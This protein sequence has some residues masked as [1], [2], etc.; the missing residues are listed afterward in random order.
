MFVLV[1]ALVAA[2]WLALSCSEQVGMQD[3]GVIYLFSARHF[4]PW[5]AHDPVASVFAQ[6]SPFPPLFPL[7]L[8]LAGGG[9][10]VV[11]AH[12]ATVLCLVLAL[13]ALYAWL[14][15]L[16]TGRATAAAVAAIFAVCPGTVALMFNVL[17]E[18]LYLAL[19]LTASALFVRT[20]GRVS[21]ELDAAS[22]TAVALVAAALMVRSV[23]VTLLPALAVYLWQRH[24]WRAVL[25]LA[26]A[27]V[28]HAA[29]SLTHQSSL[30]YGGLLKAAA[31]QMLEDFGGFL[32]GQ[33]VVLGQAL[34]Q[35]LVMFSSA[36]IL[37]FALP[38][39]A[40]A[41][42]R[43]LRGQADAV[44]LFAY[45]GLLLLWPFPD[46]AQRFAWVAVPWLVGNLLWAA[47]WAGERA[48]AVAPALLPRLPALVVLAL[49]LAVAPSPALV[50]AR[51]SGAEAAA[52]PDLR[53]VG[54]LYLPSAEEARIN[55]PMELALAHALR[56]FGARMPAG[57]CSVSIFSRLTAFY[58]KRHSLLP[59]PAYRDQ[60]GFDASLR[61]RNCRYVVMI[62]ASTPSFPEAFYPLDRLGDRV[63]I[64]ERRSAPFAG[65]E[66]PIALL[67][68]LKEFPLP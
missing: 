62:S 57:E 19:A 2:A 3:D 53:Q 32:R 22:W 68:R 20:A 23:G 14:L 61:W 39:F 44:A 36:T 54:S 21:A 64:L 8:A 30:A 46:Q 51:W 11:A 40:G 29:W 47:R 6:D 49:G 34:R 42:V 52:Q 38:A 27:V 5:I 4:A 16:G 17:S 59:P 56:D 60:A 13:A 58:G 12:V 63:E 25:P 1:A 31:P 33:A 50:A 37:L 26:A 15:A 35:N 67:A 45:A 48:R 18:P 24:R 43:A 7:L 9:Q 10:S 41:A 55:A 28:P 65:R 66:V